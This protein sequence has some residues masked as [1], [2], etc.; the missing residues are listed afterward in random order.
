MRRSRKVLIGVTGVVVAL[1]VALVLF[2]ALFDWNR[3]RPYIN[4]KVS[5]AIGRPFVIEGNL[6]AA[7]RR[8]PSESGWRSIVPWPT[9]TASDIHIDNPL[10]T[11]QPQFVRLDALQLTISPLPLLI[12][13]IYLP[14]VQ[15]VGPHVDLERN[16]K[17]EASWQLTLPQSSTPSEWAFT[18]G[19]IGFDKGDIALDDAKTRLKLHLDITPLQQAIPYDQIVSQATNDARQDVGHNVGKVVDAAKTNPDA[20]TH[21]QRTS[22][23]FAWTADGSYQGAPVTGTGKTGAVLAL[24]QS[25]QPFPVQARMHIGDS[26]IALVG[27]LTDP[28]HLGA[29]N[30]RVWFG[31]TSMAKLYPI[32]GITLPETPP[33]ATEG[34]LSAQLHTHGSHFQYNDFKGRVG[35]S[36]IGGNLEVTTGG[37]RPKLSGDLHSQQLRFVDL[38][39]LVG[40]DSKTE[41]RQRGDTTP[42]PTDKVLPV[43]QFRTDRLRTMDADVTFEA[44]HIEHPSSMP[45]DALNTHVLLDDGSLKL[46]PLHLS[47]AGGN[48]DGRLRVD[49]NAQPMHTAVDLRARHLRLKQ[50]FT[51]VQAMQNS[52]GEINGDVALNATGNSVS[53]LMGSATGELKLLMN[54][55]AISK[56]LLEAAGLNVANVVVGKLFGDKTVHINCAAADLAGT[57]GLFTSRLFVL[58]TSDATVNVDGTVDFSNEKL[59]LNVVPHTKGLRI[60]SLRTPLYVKGTFKAPDVGVHPGPLLLRGGG[61]VALAVVAAPAAALLAVIVPS[62][63]ESTNTCQT[64]LTQLH[65]E[66][67]PASPKGQGTK[68]K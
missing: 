63:G 16:S 43:E 1:V 19:T 17:G 5:A 61:A 49:G 67:P 51:T 10:W 64:V 9:F 11:K 54:D 45:I 44:T 66:P 2:V 46:D 4:D 12:H 41:K 27:T 56:T 52:L 18:L 21:A 14:S 32:L 34:H 20:S 26:K 50:L 28:V 15:L 7:W 36:D 37:A 39:P 59:D 48:I 35:D 38:A 62:R 68:S 23:Q 42:Q 24:Q 8:A 58:D 60:F 31:G 40:A 30:L 22:Y 57:N 29:L 25:D 65:H 13:H 33:Y 55:G 47:V 53:A 3:L 6:T